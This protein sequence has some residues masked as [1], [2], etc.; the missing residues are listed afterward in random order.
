M[1]TMI[2]MSSRLSPWEGSRRAALRPRHA[3]P[4]LHLKPYVPL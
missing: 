3:E 1:A 4:S 2:M